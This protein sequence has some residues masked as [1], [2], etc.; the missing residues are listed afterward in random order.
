MDNVD[1]NPELAYAAIFVEEG[2]FLPKCRGGFLVG[3]QDIQGVCFDEK[4]KDV[5]HIGFVGDLDI[6]IKDED[7]G[8]IRDSRG[9]PGRAESISDL[10]DRLVVQPEDEDDDGDS[11][12]S[13]EEDAEEE[14]TGDEPLDD[15][16]AEELDEI[17]KEYGRANFVNAA[18]DDLH[19]ASFLISILKEDPRITI[20]HS[21]TIEGFRFVLMIADPSTTLHFANILANEIADPEHRH[22]LLRSIT[23][24]THAY[25]G[26]IKHLTEDLGE[27]ITPE[28]LPKKADRTDVNHL[29]KK[30]NDA[31]EEFFALVKPL[32]EEEDE[33]G[34]ED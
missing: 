26:R 2:L 23:S 30:V 7:W 16:S 28:N 1:E 4:D 9:L 14:E 8:V 11:E 17:V 22:Q 6:A 21:G 24:D 10:Y 5:L 3:W 27:L 13:E 31:V 25:I 34:E 12:V 19:T 15:L 29:I 20:D 32:D 33:D 18:T